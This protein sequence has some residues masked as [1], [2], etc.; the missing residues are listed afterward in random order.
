MP[1]YVQTCVTFALYRTLIQNSELRAQ[2]FFVEIHQIKLFGSARYSS[3]KP[4]QVFETEIIVRKIRTV[5]K[6]AFPLPAL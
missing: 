1:D 5:Q 3:I 6:N 2:V 4:S